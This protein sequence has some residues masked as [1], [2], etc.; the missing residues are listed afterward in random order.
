MLITAFLTLANVLAAFNPPGKMKASKEFGSISDHLRSGRMTTL[1]LHLT[2]PSE[3]NPA[4]V[5]SI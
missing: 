1:R 5:T 4:N 3:L 2:G